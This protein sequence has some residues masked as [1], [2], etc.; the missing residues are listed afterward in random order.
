MTNRSQEPWLMPKI[1][2]T[3]ETNSSLDPILKKKSQ[4]R[5]VEWLKVKALRSSPSTEK[6]NKTKHNTQRK[7]II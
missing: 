4:K 6:Q 1:L 5:T 7:N 3:Q 2:A